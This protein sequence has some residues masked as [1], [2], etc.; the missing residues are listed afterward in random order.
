MLFLHTI[1][2]AFISFP[3]LS[4]RFAAN[5]CD[6]PDENNHLQST[7]APAKTEAVTMMTKRKEHLSFRKMARIK[8]HALDCISDVLQGFSHFFLCSKHVKKSWS[9]FGL[10]VNRLRVGGSDRYTNALY[11]FKKSNYPSITGCST[12]SSIRERYWFFVPSSA[13]E[14]YRATE[15]AAT[16][17]S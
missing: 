4:V 14:S 16:S 13:G 7:K 8:F 5:V 6:S 9:R 10:R 11:D 3:L 1:F 17:F 2:F 15:A 12:R